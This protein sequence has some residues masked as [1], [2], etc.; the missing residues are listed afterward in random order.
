MS[1]DFEQ[2]GL[3]ISSSDVPVIR[4]GFAN[5]IFLLLLFGLILI[6]QALN[7]FGI[8]I[9]IKEIILLCFCLATLKVYTHSIS[10]IIIKDQKTLVI[11]GPFSNTEI[12]SAEIIRTT[13]Y[14]IPSS[15]T[16]FLRL[17]KNYHF[18]L[19]SIFL[20]RYRQTMDHTLTQKGS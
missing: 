9:Y 10:K 13:V 6:N 18:Y 5:I 15:M 19:R 17:K 11:V 3:A 20:S 1:A 16:I 8:D 7:D 14:G 4:V 2:E 12:D